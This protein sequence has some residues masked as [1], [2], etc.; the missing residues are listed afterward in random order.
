LNQSGRV[1]SVAIS[2]NKTLIASAGAMNG[3]IDSPALG[4]VN[5]WDVRTGQLVRSLT[6]PDVVL[7]VRFS[8]DGKQLFCGGQDKQITIWQVSQLTAGS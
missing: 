5:L 6:L 3:L 7:S 4:K 1:L 2:P 8:P